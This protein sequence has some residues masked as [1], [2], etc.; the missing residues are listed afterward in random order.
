MIDKEVLLAAS[1]VLYM[2]YL[3]KNNKVKIEKY[4]PN[5]IIEIANLPKEYKRRLK[6]IEKI[7]HEAYYYICKII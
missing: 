6:I 5:E 2:V 7:N 4:E 3:I 1:K